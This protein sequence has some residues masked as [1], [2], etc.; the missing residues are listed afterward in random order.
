MTSEDATVHLGPGFTGVDSVARDLVALRFASRLMVEDA[1]L[2]GPKAQQE[3]AVRLG[4]VSALTHAEE[5]VAAA[6]EAR[7]ELR[8]RGITRIVLAGMGGSSLA[9]ELLSKAH[10]AALTV[11]DSTHPDQVRR[12]VGTELHHTLL[13]VASK[14]GS[15]LET[16]VSYTHLT[17]P[18]NREV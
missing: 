2:W 10:G 5:T 4:W 9:P 8:S 14:S 11:L 18:T 1:T 7:I 15:T 13:I 16:P 12:A 6:E 17:L 3:A